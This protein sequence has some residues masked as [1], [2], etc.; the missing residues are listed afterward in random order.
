[1]KDFDFEELDRAVSSA[2][3]R[4]QA[5]AR[6]EAPVERTPAAPA[7][8]R[9]ASSGRF[10]DI[11]PPSAGSRTSSSAAPSET[12]VSTPVPTPLEPKVDP[13]SYSPTPGGAVAPVE[14][15]PTEGSEP[16]QTPFIANPAIQKRPLGGPEPSLG[17]GSSNEDEL[18]RAEEVENSFTQQAPA[19]AREPE[20][21]TAAISPVHAPQGANEAPA[22]S[23]YDS[24]TFN[25]P[26]AAKKKKTAL[27]VVLWVALLVLLGAGAGAAVYFFVLQPL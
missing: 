9:A 13:L 5:S 15:A 7:S 17:N 16:A 8:R 3:G 12:P 14:E 20:P 26:P 21:Q 23:I 1:M 6:P 25:Q 18:L 24:E 10:M 27:W 22:R 4:D 2:I 11:M 19:I